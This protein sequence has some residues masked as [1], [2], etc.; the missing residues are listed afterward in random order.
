M[1]TRAYQLEKGNWLKTTNHIKSASGSGHIDKDSWIK[2]IKWAKDPDKV[3][4]DYKGVEWTLFCS[5]V[6]TSGHGTYKQPTIR[7]KE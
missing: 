7:Y 1:I 2:F 5:T 6:V 4:V 3:V